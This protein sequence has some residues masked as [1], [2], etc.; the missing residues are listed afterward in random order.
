VGIVNTTDDILRL[1]PPQDVAAEQSVLGAILLENKAINPAR[2][3]IDPDD[4]Y[5]E[6]H[7]EI[8]R[9]MVDLDQRKRSIDAITLT[10]G[11]RVRAK[12]EAIG[13]PGYILELAQCVP[14]AANVAHY[15][16]IVREKAVL[17]AV[18]SVATEIASAA[19]DTQLDL[20]GFLAEAGAKLI[21]VTRLDI[22]DAPIPL[23]EVIDN[24]V[25]DIK[26]G[27]LA[28]LPSGI[29][30]LDKELTGGGFMPSDLITC[31]GATSVGKTAIGCNI[32][33]RYKRKGVL[34]FSA[35]M[36]REHLVRRMIAEQAEIDLGA[37]S[38][39]RP[40]NPNDWE[41]ANIR[42]AAEK[43]KDY[44][45]E[46]VRYSRPTPVDVWREAWLCLQKF[47]GAL[48]LI[49]VDYA[50]LM[51]PER[52]DR[53]ERRHD[54]EIGAVTGE[55]KSLAIE[56]KV[57]VVLLSQLNREAVKANNK[58]AGTETYEPQLYHLRES[59]SLEQ[60]SDVVIMAW[61]P[62]EAECQLRCNQ[63]EYEVHWKIAKQRNG[64]RTPLRPMTFIP[65]YTKFIG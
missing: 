32:V 17:R 50:Q 22:G 19:Y 48:D 23:Y 2:A 20:R 26:N 52:A 37:L 59:G 62:T 54:L 40:A 7:R 46:V 38:R 1:V 28:G 47:D 30:T 57:P 65:K 15:A 14:T 43:L 5:R 36:S 11:L 6:S 55:L 25:A 45:L 9:T 49:V 64:A 56:L 29:A 12:L 8:F 53:R 51:R 34:L 4:F 42:A 13:G 3:I 10:D 39:R 31:A 18:A 24:V 16:R 63:G 61:E 33:T 35:E 60:D 41:W 44:P 27:E 21:A 58:P